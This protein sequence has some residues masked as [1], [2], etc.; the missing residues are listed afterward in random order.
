MRV[1]D[2]PNIPSSWPQLIHDLAD[3]EEDWVALENGADRLTIRQLAARMGSAAAALGGSAEPVLICTSDPILHTVSV[4]GSAAAGRPAMMVDSRVPDPV[5]NEIAI[6][7]GASAT[8]GRQVAGLPSVD[9]D[10]LGRLPPAAPVSRSPS[11]INTML[12]TSGST[13]VP[14]IVKR[15]VGADLCATMNLAM[16]RYPLGLGDR[17]AMLIPFASAAFITCLMGPIALKTTIV[18]ET[19]RENLGQLLADKDISGGYFVP[20]MLRIAHGV[21]GLRGSGW[22]GMRGLMIAGE[23]LDPDTLHR[24]CR[25][26]PD[27]FMLYG[28]SEHPNIAF[29]KPDEL[30]RRPGCVGKVL[31]GRELKFVEPGTATPVAAGEDGQIVFRG[32]EM[33]SGYAGDRPVG[34]WF[35]SGDVGRVDADGYL[36]VTGRVNEQIKIGG[37]RLSTQEVVAVIDTHPGVLRSAVVAVD[38]PIWSSRLAAFVVRRP[39]TTLDAEQ[40]LEWMRTQTTSYRVPRQLFFLEELPMDA[41]G[42]LAMRTLTNWASD[43]ASA[44]VSE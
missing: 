31:P 6:R 35:A 1:S 36:Y 18:F 16:R 32:P 14:K 13:G 8:I 11:S 24:I 42:K 27:A 44:P 12:L 29:A 20:T 7:S 5:V 41:S 21:D 3:A 15:S 10:D 4:L 43:P 38:D 40:L 37:N 34:D 28:M 9:A 26:F 17:Y 2:M 39:G 33:F 25:Y 30:E 22:E 19:F 23:R